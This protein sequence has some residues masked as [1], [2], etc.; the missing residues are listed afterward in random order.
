MAPGTLTDI[1]GI[2]TGLAQAIVPVLVALALLYFFWGIANF[3][4]KSGEKDERKKGK[5]RMVWGLVALFLILSVSGLL[6]VVQRTF[7]PGGG[8]H[9]IPGGAPANTLPFTGPFATPDDSVPSLHI[10]P[11]DSVNQLPPGA[12]DQSRRRFGLF[13]GGFCILGIGDCRR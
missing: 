7:F 12:L 11:D 10:A 8:L 13:R 4:L 6:A 9:D 1:I 3:I 2:A 5:E